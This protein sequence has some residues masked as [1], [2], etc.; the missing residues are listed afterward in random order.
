[1]LVVLQQDDTRVRHDRHPTRFRRLSGWQPTGRLH[2]N[3]P[4]NTARE[5][6][7]GAS[8]RAEPERGAVADKGAYR[9]VSDP[10]RAARQ[11]AV[12]WKG[13]HQREQ[14]DGIGK[15]SVGG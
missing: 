6:T 4:G 7:R 15:L 5:W 1:G 8:L 14:R 2:R 3:E 10:V 11:G 13:P 12:L 9:E